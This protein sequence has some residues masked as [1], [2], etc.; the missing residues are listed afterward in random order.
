MSTSDLKFVL[1][2]YYLGRLQQQGRSVCR[3]MLVYACFFAS[4]VVRSRPRH[5]HLTTPSP[6][7]TNAY[8][9]DTAA[10]GPRGRK[11]CLEVTQRHYER[12]MAQCERLRLLRGEDLRAWEA[13]VRG[14]GGLVT[15]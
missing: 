9:V 7:K 14:G 3:C 1:V 2:D 11:A 8:T 12:F 5:S 15:F 6:Q 10:S 4:S 13:E